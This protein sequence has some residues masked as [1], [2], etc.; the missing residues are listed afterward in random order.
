V[1]N[2][3]LWIAILFITL[4]PLYIVLVA[5]VSD[6]NA[7]YRGDV[8][9]KPIGFTLLGYETVFQYN[10][11]WR[12]Y[13]NSVIYTV[14]GTLLSIAVTMTAA[15]ALTRKFPGKK[16]I[17]LIFVF[18][19]LFN[20]GLIPTFLVLRDLGLYNNPLIMI[21]NGCLSVWNLMITR[22]YISSTIPDEILEAAQLD[23]ASYFRYF[24][25]ILLPMSGTIIAVLT[26]YYGVAKWNDFYTG[27]IYLRDRS[28]FP[29]QTLLRE[30]LAT[31]QV[32]NIA[33]DSLMAES[34]AQVDA[35]KTAQ[36]AKYCII[37][38]ST[39]PAVLLY[40]L[41]QKYFVKGVM[42]GSLKG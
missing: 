11:M 15:F 39:G 14:L 9:W 8:I 5:S 26:V 41:M 18:I 7:V 37:V 33:F 3:A 27:L 42:I 30:I 22:T 10:E 38:I 36:L 31:L 2:A 40:I 13:L 20:G 24:I 32:N 4:Y 6:P 19:M 34:A 23:G 25:Y 12:C 1:I 35:V 16:F 28:L 21:L 17:N 29:L